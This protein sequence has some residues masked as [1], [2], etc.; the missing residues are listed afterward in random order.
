MLEY[1]IQDARQQNKSGICVLKQ[2]DEETFL[3]DRNL[4]NSLVPAG[5]ELAG[6]Y[7]LRHCLLM[8]GCRGLLIV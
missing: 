5:G 2:Q 4:W 8:A 1:C 7:E 3:T 6:E